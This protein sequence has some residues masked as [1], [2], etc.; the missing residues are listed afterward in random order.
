MPRVRSVVVSTAFAMGA[1]KLGHPVPLSNFASDVNNSW[2]QPAHRKTPA[3]CSAFNGL[4]PA[5]SVPCFRR[6]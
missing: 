6:T 5:R 3:R 2:P 4:V 1:Q